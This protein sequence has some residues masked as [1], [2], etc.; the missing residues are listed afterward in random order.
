MPALTRLI[1]V[2]RSVRVAGIV[3]VA[4]ILSAGSAQVDC[5]AKDDDQNARAVSRQN[6]K[7]LAQ[8]CQKYVEEHNNELPPAAVLDKEGKALY[9]WRVA[10]L[11][12]LGERKL[13]E[14]F[15][16]NEPWDSPANMK[17]LEKMP[18]VF[19]PVPGYA[20]KNHLTY[21]QVFVGP[22]TLFSRKGR[23][24]RFPGSFR[25]GTTN[26]ILIIEAG[27]AVPWTAPREIEYD[28]K[29]PIPK[30]GGQFKEGYNLVAA[31]GEPMFFRN[32]KLTE[33]TLRNAIDP[34]D[35][36]VLGTD[37]QPSADR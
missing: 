31:L 15:N 24:P 2:R 1:S 11:P 19:A 18:N 7:L 9:S 12:Y 29:K 28:V 6:L 32:G 23:G 10:I 33:K 16:R 27:D 4:G 14:E 30:L 36:N 26:T 35:G 13:Y 25:D 21:Y 22:N 34:S 5:Y 3:L 17:V 37:W 8:A 20:Q